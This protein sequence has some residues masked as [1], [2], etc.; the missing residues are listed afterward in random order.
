MAPHSLTMTMVG[1]SLLWV[2]WF[3]FNA[4]SNLEAN[5]IA[6]LA[7]INTFVATAAAAVSWLFVE[8]VVKRQG[9]AARH[10]SRARSPASSRS[11]RPPASP[12]RWASIVL[13]LVARRG[14]LLLR[15]GGEERARL[16]RQPRRLRRPLRRRHR[17]RDR[18]P[19][20][21]STPP[22]A[23]SASSTTPPTRRRCD[24]PT[25]ADRAGHGAGQGR[26]A[27]AALVG[28]RLARS[29]TSSSTWSSACASRRRRSARAS[30]SPSTASAPTTTESWRGGALR[31]P[32]TSSQT[33]RRVHPPPFFLGRFAALKA[34]VRTD[35][36]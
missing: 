15:L 3:G 22:S 25:T 13:G 2:G 24:R 5:G 27:D 32:S 11:R 9:V 26:A 23:A 17:R 16:R 19:A 29:S 8:W 1:A 7:M 6:A 10:A 33:G 21:W 20:S 28:H 18:R 14:L 36:G 35:D 31:S 34:P 12:A 4:G 30:T